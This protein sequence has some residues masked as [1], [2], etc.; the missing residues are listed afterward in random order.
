MTVPDVNAL[1]RRVLLTG[2]LSIFLF[3]FTGWAVAAL[4]ADG[5]WFLIA[6]ALEYLLV[7]RP[8]MRPV[9]DAVKLR[10]RLAYQAWLDEQGP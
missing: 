5:G 1:K 3:F 10:R 4:D 7:V 6:L 9:R 2:A 8:L